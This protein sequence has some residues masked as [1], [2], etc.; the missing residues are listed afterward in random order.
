MMRSVRYEIK[1]DFLKGQY[2]EA[3]PLQ[4]GMDHYLAENVRSWKSRIA[5]T[6][7]RSAAIEGFMPRQGLAPQIRYRK[8]PYPNMS[9][10]IRRDN[11]TSPSIRSYP[12]HVFTD[13][14]FWMKPVI[15]NTGI[16]RTVL[17]VNL[18]KIPTATSD[19]L[20]FNTARQ[21]V[22]PVGRQAGQTPER[23]HKIT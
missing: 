14:K 3:H 10:R 21:S 23:E 6:A 13:Q 12:E 9:P 22:W 7:Y 4:Q 5:D 11:A 18:A 1:S 16:R 19:T 20:L 17:K 15:Q 2:H 8:L